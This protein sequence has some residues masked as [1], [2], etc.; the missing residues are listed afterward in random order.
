MKNQHVELLFEKKKID[1]YET[2]I[3]M[4]EKYKSTFK[5]YKKALRNFVKG[6]EKKYVFPCKM[7]EQLQHALCDYSVSLELKP[8]ISGRGKLF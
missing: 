2:T 6:N 5:F 4:D 3:A 7:D 1:L 8:T